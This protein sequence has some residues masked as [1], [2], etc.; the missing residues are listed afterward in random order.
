VVAIG[1]VLLG[2]ARLTVANAR[3]ACLIPNAQ[4]PDP[5]NRLL[6]GIRAEGNPAR[7]GV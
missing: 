2:M 4:L 1:R 7:L 6:A 5:P 3:P